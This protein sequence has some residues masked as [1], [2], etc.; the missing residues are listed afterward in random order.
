MKVPDE[1]LNQLTEI[2]SSGFVLFMTNEEGDVTIYE[3]CDTG[4]AMSMITERA[5][6]WVKASSELGAIQMMSE[7]TVEDDDDDEDL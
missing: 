4:G 3:Y 5:R 6:Q 1:I 7:L 2:S